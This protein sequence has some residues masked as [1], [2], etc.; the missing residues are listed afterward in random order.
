MFDTWSATLRVKFDADQFTVTDV[1]NLLSR[2]GGQ[3]GIGEGRPDSKESA[4]MG[5][6]TFRILTHEEIMR[7]A[8]N[9][10]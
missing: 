9:V 10:A 3:V 2:A 4:G 6:G 1:V 8:A 5:W 7:G